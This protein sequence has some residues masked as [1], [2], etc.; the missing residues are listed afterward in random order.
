MAR[1]SFLLNNKPGAGILRNVVS[2]ARGPGFALAGISNGTN[3]TQ[4]GRSSFF[5]ESG[6]ALSSLALMYS[7][8]YTDGTNEAD[9]PNAYTV[10]ASVEYPSGTFTQV[11]WGGATSKSVAAGTNETSDMIAVAIPVNAQFWVRGFVT[12]TAGQKWPISGSSLSAALGELGEVGVG[13]SDKT[14]SGTISGSSGALRPSAIVAPYVAGMKKVSLAVL[15]DSLAAGSGDGN[16]D[17]RGNTGGYSRGATGRCPVMTIAVGGTRMQNQVLSGKMDRRMDLLRKA[18]VTHVLTNWSVN[19]VSSSRTQAQMQA[20]ML[21]FWQWMQGLGIKPVQTTLTPKTASTDSWQSLAN[22][23]IDSFFTGGSS[24][25]RS[26]VNANTRGLPAPLFDYVEIANVTE[27]TIDSGKWGCGSG[28]STHLGVVDSWTVGAGSTTTSV[29]S[30]STKATNYYQFGGALVFTSGALSGTR[31]TVSSNTSGGTFTVP[32][33]ASAPAS[34][35]T[36]QAFPSTYGPTNDGTHPNVTSTGSFLGGH[37]IMADQTAAK[38][39][40]WNV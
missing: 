19:D 18:G 32:T 37:Y 28:F 4:N 20:D 27:S 22:Q 16:F 21:T 12:V 9:M 17:A 36:F 33:M 34:G 38:I 14:M 2:A 11:T 29:T 5:N 23:T 24:S 10:S 15:G 13:L 26:L 30:N 8:W 3:T 40:F 39:D 7:G 25:I 1:R 35:D 6:K 31:A